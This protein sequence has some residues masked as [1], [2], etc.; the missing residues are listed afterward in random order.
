VEY[1]ERKGYGEG[2]ITIS[3]PRSFLESNGLMPSP[4]DLFP[5]VEV[6]YSLLPIFN[7]FPRS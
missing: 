2:I 1:S 6:P 5:D 3:V 4:V 7:Q